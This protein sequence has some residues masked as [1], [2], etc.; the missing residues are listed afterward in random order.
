ML[1]LQRSHALELIALPT[2]HAC[3]ASHAPLLACNFLQMISISAVAVV[4][5]ASLQVVQ[6]NDA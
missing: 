6:R 2:M 4:A 3:Y 1:A 5:Q